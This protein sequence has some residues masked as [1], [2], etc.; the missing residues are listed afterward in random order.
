MNQTHLFWHWHTATTARPFWPPAT[1]KVSPFQNI[2][3]FFSISTMPYHRP[4]N[5]T[6]PIHSLLT[7]VQ[8]LYHVGLQ[9]TRSRH[10][11]LPW[12]LTKPTA[13]SNNPMIPVHWTNINSINSWE[14]NRHSASQEIPR[15]LWNPKV[16]YRI[17][18]RSSP[19]PVLSQINLVHGSPSIS[20]RP[21]LTLRLLMSYIYGAP[22]L[23]VSRSHTTT[24]HSR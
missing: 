22:I 4:F 6:R 20:W 5:F 16:H 8:R 1:R 18:K 17:Y 14:A 21:I 10:S 2:P 15:L 19:V 23:D 9:W 3:R 13:H 12:I 24:Q 11:N 7:H